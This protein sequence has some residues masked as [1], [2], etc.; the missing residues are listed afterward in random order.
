[1]LVKRLENKMYEEC[2]RG[3]F[4]LEKRGLRRDLIVFYNHLKGVCSTLVSF[5]R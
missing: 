1:M 3:L 2:L 5:L 4:S